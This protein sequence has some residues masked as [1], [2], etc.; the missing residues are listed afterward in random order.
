MVR[1]A[2]LEGP[3][4]EDG[5]DH[6]GS[7]EMTLS[8]E[9]TSEGEGI[10]TSVGQDVTTSVHPFGVEKGLLGQCALLVG[11]GLSRQIRFFLL[12]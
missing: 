4:R 8:H 7:Q 10:A 2:H 1:P 11:S 3:S 5:K 12:M 9:C 6:T